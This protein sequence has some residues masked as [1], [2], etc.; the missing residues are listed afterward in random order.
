MVTS[1]KSE[2][3]IYGQHSPLA[4]PDTPSGGLNKGRWAYVMARGTEIRH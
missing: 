1:G 4:C 2:Y 3:Q